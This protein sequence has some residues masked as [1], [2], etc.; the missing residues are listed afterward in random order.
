[1]AYTKHNFKQGE[2]LTAQALNEMDAQIFANEAAISSASSSTKSWSFTSDYQTELD[3]VVSKVTTL[4]GNGKGYAVS[5]ITYSDLH[6]ASVTDHPEF[7]RMIDAINY[8]TTK[9]DIKFVANL[10]DTHDGTPVQ[11]SHYGPGINGVYSQV[12]E[13][14]SQLNAPYINIPGNHDTIQQVYKR[15]WMTNIPNAVFDKVG[16]WFYTDDDFY[17]VR[18]IVLDCQDQD[19]HANAWTTGTL[20]GADRSYEQLNWLANTALKTSKRIIFLQHQSMESRTGSFVHPTKPT[21]DG[22]YY[23]T[24]NIIDAFEQGTSTEIDYDSSRKINVDFTS[25]GNGVVL[26]NFF[27]HTHGDAILKRDSGSTINEIAIDDALC[28]SGAHGGSDNTKTSNTVN[29]IAFDVVCVDL[30]NKTVYCYRFGTGSD[31]ELAL[32]LPNV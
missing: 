17:N 13:S 10:G 28:R 14:M 7:D 6:K 9:L 20:N 5:F 24:E 26:C 1:M 30:I 32:N 21:S 25:Q 11:G 12:L 3:R 2:V 22:R 15:N 23:F 8:L 31:R 16:S 29:E 19:G 27:G 4:Q 18:F